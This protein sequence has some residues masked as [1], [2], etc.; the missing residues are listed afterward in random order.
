MMCSFLCTIYF[1][2]FP[3]DVQF[4]MW[5]RHILALLH[6]LPAKLYPF[7]VKDIFILD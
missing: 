1:K 6:H 2:I 7:E 5:G 3:G 4:S